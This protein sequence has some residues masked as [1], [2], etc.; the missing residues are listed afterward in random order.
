MVRQGPVV[1]IRTEQAVVRPPRAQPT[2]RES[3]L[4]GQLELEM[5]IE[6]PC[7]ESNTAAAPGPTSGAEHPSV[8]EA[9]E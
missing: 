1:C 4:G 6:F 5:I 7:R 8:H 9:R 2:I 3:E